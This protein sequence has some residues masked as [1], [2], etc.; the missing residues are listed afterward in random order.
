MTQQPLVNW[1]PVQWHPEEYLQAIGRALRGPTK[2][3]PPLRKIGRYWTLASAADPVPRSW[4]F[5]TRRAAKR[6]FS[7]PIIITSGARLTSAFGRRP[8][9]PTSY[10]YPV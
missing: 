1:V 6:Y 2:I 4:R 3:R 9:N 10:P 8:S 5:G 7:K